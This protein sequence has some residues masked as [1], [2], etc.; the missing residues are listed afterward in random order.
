[1]TFRSYLLAMAASTLVAWIAWFAILF[2]IDPA[3]A[4]IMGF[5]L[6]YVTLGTGLLGA[7]TLLGLVYRV[8]IAAHTNIRIREV[9][10]AFR[11]AILLSF[12]AVSSLALSAQEL[13]HWWVLI[14]LIAV[15]VAIEYASLL[16]QEA[17]R[18]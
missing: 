5:V 2:T 4:G 15:V 12:V 16:I 18:K 9:R 7:L 13:L 3:Q 10:I 11:H 8:K 1:M 14:V 17:R 6:F